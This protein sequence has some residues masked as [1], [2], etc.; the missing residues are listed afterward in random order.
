M[1]EAN[2]LG[3]AGENAAAD[4]LKRRGYKIL[5]RNKTVVGVEFDIIAFK[6]ETVCFVE[7]KTRASDQSG[8]PEEFVDEWKIQRLIRGAKVY[9]EQKRFAGCKA[10]FDVMSMLWE[11]N[12]FKI[13]HIEHAFEEY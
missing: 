13:D 8:L 3:K 6:D 2:S 10:R 5:A 11:N 9:Y 12:R 1:A 7:V 4:Y